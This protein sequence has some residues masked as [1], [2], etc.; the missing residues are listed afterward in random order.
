VIK[1]A[2]QLQHLHP[3]VH[4]P[5]YFFCLPVALKTLVDMLKADKIH[6]LSVLLGLVADS[7][8]SLSGDEY[9]NDW[10]NQTRCLLT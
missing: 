9:L 7:N 6:V 3:F 5:V 8:L 2:S 4:N 10:K 1:I